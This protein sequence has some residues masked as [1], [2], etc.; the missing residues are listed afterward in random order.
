MALLKGK[1]NKVEDPNIDINSDLDLGEFEDD[2]SLDSDFEISDD[3]ADIIDDLDLSDDEIMEETVSTEEENDM[4]MSDFDDFI[5]EDSA[6]QESARSLIEPMEKA[7]EMY[8]NELDLD[9]DEDIDLDLAEDDSSDFSDLSDFDLDSDILGENIENESET[10]ENEA[11][12]TSETD[13][14]TDISV[15]APEEG[16]KCPNC[17]AELAPNSG[18]CSNCGKPLGEILDYDSTTPLLHKAQTPALINTDEIDFS[19]AIV[20]DKNIIVKTEKG[21][22]ALTKVETALVYPIEC[23]EDMAKVLVADHVLRVNNPDLDT[24]ITAYKFLKG[25]S[26]ELM[27]LYGTDN[28]NSIYQEDVNAVLE[29][30]GL[31]RTLLSLP[32]SNEVLRI[33]AKAKKKDQKVI[34]ECI[35]EFYESYMANED[36]LI[37][38]KPTALDIT[39]DVN[40][41][42]IRKTLAEE[43]RIYFILKGLM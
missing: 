7:Q 38:S 22:K 31:D 37:I 12:L 6:M 17:G 2:F 23:N 35:K 28:L 19:D 21:Y 36:E 27:E 42:K 41:E 32:L 13:T 10:G 40:P 18:F 16:E 5:E 34:A 25:Q 33:F 9:L 30:A 11:F 26:E 4:I 24:K 20:G 1:K 8:E 39:F 14:S 43:A 29:F 3:F 15:D